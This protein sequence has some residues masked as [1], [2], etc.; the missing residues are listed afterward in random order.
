VTGV[1]GTS[2]EKSDAEDA[3]CA[4]PVVLLSFQAITRRLYGLEALALVLLFSG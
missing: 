3:G 1:S 2:V 4:P